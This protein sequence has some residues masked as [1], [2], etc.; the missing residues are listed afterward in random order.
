[1]TA[2][3]EPETAPVGEWIS[4]WQPPNPFERTPLEGRDC[5]VEPLNVAAHGEALFDAWQADG[6]SRWIYLGGRPFDDRKSCL[7][8]LEHQAVL[9]DPMFMALVDQDSDRALGVAAW[10]NITPEHGTIEL[11]HLSFSTKMA[12]TRMATEALHLLIDHAFTLGYRRMAWKCDAL[13]APSRRAARRLG[14]RFEGLFR[15]HRVVQ[16]R[17]RDTSWFALLDHEWP[18]IA[19]AHRQWLAPDNFDAQGRQQQALSR[20]TA[21]VLQEE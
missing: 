6:A 17:N 7:R 5:R 11:G 18:A 1:M 20:L 13:N 4:N 10:L 14:F 9:R 2:P 8:W 3:T 16:G 15:Q 19:C 21:R 12:G